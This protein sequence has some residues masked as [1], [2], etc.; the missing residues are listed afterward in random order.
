MKINEKELLKADF[1]KVFDILK[2]YLQSSSQLQFPGKKP[3]NNEESS[4]V[5]DEIN[6]KIESTDTRK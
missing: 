1:E 6:K 5:I 4:I 2:E 3:I